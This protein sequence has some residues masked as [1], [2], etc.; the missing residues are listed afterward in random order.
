MANVPQTVSMSIGIDEKDCPLEYA[1]AVCNLFAQLGARGTS[2]L[3]ASGDDGVG[4]GDCRIKD[5]SVRFIPSFPASCPYVTSVGGTTSQFPQVGADL[6]GGGFSNYFPRPAYQ[7]EGVPAFLSKLGRQYRGIYN[8][9]GRGIPDLS[10]QALNFVVVVD[11]VVQV[12]NG[13][14]CAVSTMA[15]IVSLLNDFLISNGKDPLGFLNPWLYG[16]G[17]AGLDDIIYG[18]NP[19]CGTNG[20]FAANGWDPVTGLGTIDFFEMQHVIEQIIIQGGA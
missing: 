17:L 18:Y 1:K 11:N 6:S 10:S 12:V 5:G 19:G 7:N 8:R 13:T 2:V 3:V 15:G 20:F 16:H 14:R 9:D 4:Y